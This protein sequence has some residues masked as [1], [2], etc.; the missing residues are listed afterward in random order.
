L[1]PDGRDLDPEKVWSLTEEDAYGL[2]ADFR[3][4]DNGGNPYCPRC[5]CLEPYSVRRR[6]FRCS[7]PECRAEFSVTSGTVFA[8]R[9]L[10]FKKII[11]AIWE[12]ITAAKGMA[13][14][15]L[16][17]K[18]NVQYK[19]AYVLLRHLLHNAAKSPLASGIRRG[20]WERSSPQAS[21]SANA[22]HPWLSEAFSPTMRLLWHSRWRGPRP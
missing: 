22:S 8:N 15:H 2:F 4:A 18:L 21:L 17:R 9:K 14:L 7:E 3:W 12:E 10:S 5:G 19:T 13:A 16:S 1:R 6:R 20:R 11:M